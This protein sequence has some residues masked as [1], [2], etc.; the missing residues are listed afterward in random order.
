[1]TIYGVSSV[2]PELRTALRPREW[3]LSFSVYIAPYYWLL[4]AH[5]KF[6]L[7]PTGYIYKRN[8]FSE[9][10]FPQSLSSI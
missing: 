9:F 5:A 3:R 1:M 4:R 7:K 2:S 6:K 8:E 10:S